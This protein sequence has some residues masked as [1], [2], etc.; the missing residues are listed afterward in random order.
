MPAIIT[1]QLHPSIAL[2]LD[3]FTGHHNNLNTAKASKETAV[4]PPTMLQLTS[5]LH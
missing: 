1:T 5:N 2:R 3:G 4:L